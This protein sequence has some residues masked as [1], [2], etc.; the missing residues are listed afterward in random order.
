MK[1]TLIL[2][3]T[4]YQ[5][6]FAIQLANSIKN[7]ESVHIAITD[8]SNN[9][10]EIYKNILK[11]SVFDNA[12]FVK[13]KKKTSKLSNFFLRAKEFSSS[14]FGFKT[15]QYI[16]TEIYDE[17]IC[18]GPSLAAH[19][20]YAV[21]INTNPRV[22]VNFFE[23]GVLSYQKQINSSRRIKFLYKLRSLLNWKNMISSAKNFYCF[24]P[25]VY[26]GSM[27]CIKVP[28]IDSNS[29]IPFILRDI[30]EIDDSNRYLQKYIFFTSVYD[31][32]G[33]KPIGEYQTALRVKEI[34]G[35]DNLLIKKHP[36]DTRTIF[37]DN[38][39]IV[40]SNS[41]V[42]W[43]VIQL[44]NDF[45][46]KVFLTATSGVVLGGNLFCSN[47]VR[48]FYLFNKCDLSGNSAA[49]KTQNRIEEVLLN[50]EMKTVLGFVKICTKLEEIVSNGS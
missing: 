6:I 1:K 3:D 47:P 27:T 36:R 4:Y 24:Y 37:E 20:I 21:L 29:N 8:Q 25:E 12:Y 17:L 41:N 16:F 2:C 42:P 50:N 28:L 13:T 45:S 38:G 33:G 40:D 7:K 10:Y 18:C 22:E 48:T 34:V 44:S 5:V 43:E 26:Y 11:S 49:L 39:F 30:F 46:N 31:F 32:E 14:L 15:K 23:E 19:A 35:T 9:S